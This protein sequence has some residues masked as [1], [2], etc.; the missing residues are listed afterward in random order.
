[1][2]WLRKWPWKRLANMILPNQ[3]KSNFLA[4]DL[5]LLKAF[6][7]WSPSFFE[8]ATGKKHKIFNI[9]LMVLSSPWYEISVISNFIENSYFYELYVTMI[10]Q[11]PMKLTTLAIENTTKLS[12][13]SKWRWT[14]QNVILKLLKKPMQKIDER[15]IGQDCQTR[16]SWGQYTITNHHAR[17]KQSQKQQQIVTALMFFNGPSGSWFHLR[18]RRRWAYAF[19]DFISASIVWMQTHFGMPA[20]QW[21]QSKRATCMNI[22]QCPLCYHPVKLLLLGKW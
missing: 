8:E 18:F 16:N 9:I 13:L 21:V 20:K 17:P 3:R 14:K 6:A 15:L 12:Q 19:H 22:N 2:Y 4:Q 1:M 11:I 10:V 5:H 7:M